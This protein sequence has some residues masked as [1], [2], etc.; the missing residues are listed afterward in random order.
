MNGTGQEHNKI[1]RE[2][3]DDGIIAFGCLI[4]ISSVIAGICFVIWQIYSWAKTGVWTSLPLSLLFKYFGVNLESVYNPQSWFGLAKVAK[5]VL[6]QP[7]SICIPI[8]VGGITYFICWL[9]DKENYH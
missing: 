2:D 9:C 8:G 6:K 7:I 1:E 4:F 5:W 3:S